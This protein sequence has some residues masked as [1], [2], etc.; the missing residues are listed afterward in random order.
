MRRA[1]RLRLAFDQRFAAIGRFDAEDHFG[2]FRT[3][4][5]QQPGKADDFTRSHRQFERRNHAF[6]RSL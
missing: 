5:L 1:Q 6:C 3:S 2:G 4:E